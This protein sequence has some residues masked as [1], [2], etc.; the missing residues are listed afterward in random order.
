M[1]SHLITYLASAMLGTILGVATLVGADSR[2]IDLACTRA[3]DCRS[4]ERVDPCQTADDCAAP[5]AIEIA[6]NSSTGVGCDRSADEMVTPCQPDD[7]GCDGIIRLADDGR[8]GGVGDRIAPC[9]PDDPGCD[10]LGT[11]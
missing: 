3:S 5:E 10:E 4:D 7:P 8:G 1:N 9:N 6:C 11:V 2:Q